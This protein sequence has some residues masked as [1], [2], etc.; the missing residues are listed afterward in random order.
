MQYTLR[1][2][3]LCSKVSLPYNTDTTQWFRSGRNSSHFI[4]EQGVKLSVTVH[5]MLFFFHFKLC[6]FRRSQLQS[7][8][9]QYTFLQNKSR[10]L[11]GQI[12]HSLHDSGWL[13]CIFKGQSVTA[14]ARL[15]DSL[16]QKQG[17][18]RHF[19]LFRVDIFSMK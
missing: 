3:V 5:L 18:N 17:A 7:I 10:R 12:W 15:C 1:V 2:Y 13:S 14:R 4:M 19:D 11:S 16:L 6:R 8:I 9:F